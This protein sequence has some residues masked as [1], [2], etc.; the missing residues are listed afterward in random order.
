MSRLR[1]IWLVAR[2]ELL[3]R[4]RSKG[5]LAGLVLTQVFVI[6]ALLLQVFLASGENVLKIGLT[7]TPD[8]RLQTAI[9]TVASLTDTEVELQSYPD[10]SAG[11]AALEAEAATAIDRKDI[12]WK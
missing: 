6:G 7:G 3:E 2:R 10:R 9:Q 12:V 1:A 5:F 8:P 4:G 11:E